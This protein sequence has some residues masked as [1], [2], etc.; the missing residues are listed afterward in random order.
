VRS[1]SRQIHV[2]GAAR[3]SSQSPLGIGGLSIGRITFHDCTPFPH[4]DTSQTWTDPTG[5]G[6]TPNHY[7]RRWPLARRVHG[8]GRTPFC[9][10]NATRLRQSRATFPEL[11]CTTRHS[12]VLTPMRNHAD[13]HRSNL[14]QAEGTIRMRLT[15][16]RTGSPGGLE[17]GAKSEELGTRNCGIR[18]SGEC[19]GP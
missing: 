7:P 15:R 12:L 4:S 17:R 18:G 9:L 19:T 8:S 14:D 10:L 2:L 11:P 5:G 6:T 1:G 3:V 13:I 16:Q